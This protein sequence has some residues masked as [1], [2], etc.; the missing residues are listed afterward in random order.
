MCKF[1]FSGQCPR[2][3]RYALHQTN[4]CPA[5]LDSELLCKFQFVAL[6]ESAQPTTDHN[7]HCEEHGGN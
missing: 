5:P 6:F 2:T 1:Q 4:N 7:C 3:M